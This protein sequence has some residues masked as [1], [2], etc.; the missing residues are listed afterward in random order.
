MPYVKMLTKNIGSPDSDA[1]EETCRHDEDTPEAGARAVID[2][3]NSTLRPKEKPRELVRV[4]GEVKDDDHD[5]SKSLAMTQ[6]DGRGSSYDKMKCK[7][8]GIT[9]RRYGLSSTTERDLK[10]RAKKYEKCPG[11]CVR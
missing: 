4:I 1:W 11:N 5:W 2:Y 3:Y 6:T 9:G 10:Y 7:R 8:C